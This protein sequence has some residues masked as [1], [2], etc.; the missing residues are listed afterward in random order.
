MTDKDGW[1][2]LHYSVRSGSYESFTYFTD[3]RSD[4][5]LKANIGWNCLHIAALNEH[6][7]ICKTLAEKHKIDVHMTDNDGWTA[8]H[9]SARNG[10]Y[11]L[12]TYFIDLGNDIHLKTNTGSNCLYIAALN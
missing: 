8:I 9:Y 3:L 4:I 11:E 2:V 10:S 7:N 1:I 5:H 6:L 12:V